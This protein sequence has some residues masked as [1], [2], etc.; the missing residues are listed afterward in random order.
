VRVCVCVCK[1]IPVHMRARVYECVFV[2]QNIIL[3]RTL[4]I[5]KPTNM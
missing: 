4:R 1:R 2:Q 5:L 3:C